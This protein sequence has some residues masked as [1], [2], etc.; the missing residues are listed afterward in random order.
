MSLI[1]NPCP[2]W[3]QSIVIQTIDHA[4]SWPAL[5]KTRYCSLTDVK[6]TNSMRI[7]SLLKNTVA[8][9]K[10]RIAIKKPGNKTNG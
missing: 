1:P 7:Y 5:Y 2:L 10:L 3:L 6:L 9:L 8:K 4:V